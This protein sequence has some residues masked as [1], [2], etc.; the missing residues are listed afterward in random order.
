[1]LLISEAMASRELSSCAS[2]KRAAAYLPAADAM[3]MFATGTV[4]ALGCLY[5][6]I[7][8]WDSTTKHLRQDEVWEA[9]VSANE[10]GF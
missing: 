10:T 2:W 3:A 8:L 5:G 9:A 7:S 4:L 1:M 6:W